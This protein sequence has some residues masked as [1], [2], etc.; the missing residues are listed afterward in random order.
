MTPPHPFT[1]KTQH[2]PVTAGGP[3]YEEKVPPLKLDT[4]SLES[5]LKCSIDKRQQLYTRNQGGSVCPVTL[6][7]PALQFLKVSLIG[8]TPKFEFFGGNLSY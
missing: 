8:V 1:R 4:K 2:T 6:R 5:Y 7:P 3:Q